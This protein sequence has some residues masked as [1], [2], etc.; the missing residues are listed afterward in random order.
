VADRAVVR[1]LTEPAL[2]A[3]RQSQALV[4][5]D[6]GTSRLRLSLVVDGEIAATRAGPGIAETS[7]APLQV[8][9]DCVA[10]WRQAHGALDVYL[11]GMVGSRNGIHE[12]AYVPLPANCLSWSRACWSTSFEGAVLTV[13]GGLCAPNEAQAGDV[14]RGE[15]TQIFGALRVSPRL[16]TGRHVCVLPGTHSKWVE[17]VEGQVVRFRTALTGETYAL[18]CAH[19]TLLKAAAS[20]DQPG[21]WQRGFDAGAQ[22]ARQLAEGLLAA[23]FEART[24]QLLA[25][26]SRAWAAA[27]LSGLLIG[28]EID[29]V[30]R[31]FDSQGEITVIGEPQLAALYRNVLESHGRSAHVLAG[32]ACAIQGLLYLADC[33]RAHQ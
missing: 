24:Q 18:L 15:E 22:R 27:F 28:Y 13:A 6:W 3:A 19:S 10:A 29:T 17:V 21:D 8:L 14:M 32:D 2:S 31:T 26:R 9:L 7:V 33:R 20:A 5:G 30:G 1:I 4:L 23:M 11:S 25:G 16:A 12:V